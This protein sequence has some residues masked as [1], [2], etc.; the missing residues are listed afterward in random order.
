M[1]TEQL[2]RLVRYQWSK[3]YAIRTEGEW[4]DLPEPRRQHYRDWTAGEFAN[5]MPEG[6]QLADAATVAAMKRAVAF[7]QAHDRLKDAKGSS[8]KREALILDMWN[9]RNA[10]TDDDLDRLRAWLDGGAG[11]G[12]GNG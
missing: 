10:F 11:G 6:W 2:E 8:S 1:S 7:I 9:V 3:S 5:L 4:D 12:D